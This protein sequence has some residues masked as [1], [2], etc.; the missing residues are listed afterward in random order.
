MISVTMMRRQKW[1]QGYVAVASFQKILHHTMTNQ[2]KILRSIDIIIKLTHIWIGEN[3][4]LAKG[5]YPQN[6]SYYYIKEYNS[7]STKICIFNIY[8]YGSYTLQLPSNKGEKIKPLS[9]RV[10]ENWSC[11][12]FHGIEFLRNNNQP[13]SHPWKA[14]RKR[15]TSRFSIG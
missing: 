8:I 1:N 5:N 3:T 12:N 4:K 7:L 6:H 9:N 13:S 11:F 10:K 2:T 15:S 14:S